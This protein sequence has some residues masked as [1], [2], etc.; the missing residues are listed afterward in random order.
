MINNPVITETITENSFSKLISGIITVFLVLGVVYFLFFF[1][2][3]AFTYISSGGDE[4]KVQMAKSQLTNAL[5]GLVILFLVFAILQIIGS[6]F[7]IHDIFNIP[8]PN[9]L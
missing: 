7:G 3:G 4:K 9:L 8:L 6:F 2:T 1:M 5:I